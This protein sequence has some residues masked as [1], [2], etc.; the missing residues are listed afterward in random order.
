MHK[1]DPA[2][3]GTSRC[4]VL[5][6]P[7]L[8]GSV[9]A[10]AELPAPIGLLHNRVDCRFEPFQPGIV[11]RKDH[12]QQ[13]LPEKFSFH[14]QPLVIHPGTVT[15]GSLPRIHQPQVNGMQTRAQQRVAQTSLPVPE[16]T[17]RPLQGSQEAAVFNREQPPLQLG[18][19]PDGLFLG[20]FDACQRL[21]EQTRQRQQFLPRRR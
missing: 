15:V 14:G 20:G 18:I 5:S 1:P 13:R 10:D 8:L 7:A 6:Y 3:R 21:L 11:D 2:L 19:V 16:D 12:A 4:Q 9:I 17:P